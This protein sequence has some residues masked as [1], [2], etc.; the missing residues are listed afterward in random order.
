MKTISIE[1]IYNETNERV[2][3]QAL[4]FVKDVQHSEDIAMKVFAKINRLNKNP[5]TCFNPNESS[6]NTWVYRITNHMIL[7]YF[8]SKHYNKY[9]NVSDFGDENDPKDNF[10]FEAS[11]QS[12]A[13]TDIL[14]KELEQRID[15]AFYNLKPEYRKIA[16]LFFVH[17]FTYDEICTDLDLPMGTVKGMLSRCREKLQTELKDLYKVKAKTTA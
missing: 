10:E 13:D 14:N 8:R 3:N 15:L 16:T 17:Q 9:K 5:L 2:L 6:L 4:R 12:N 11:K 7:D 1:K